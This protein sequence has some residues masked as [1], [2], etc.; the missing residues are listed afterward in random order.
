MIL[1]DQYAWAG[2]VFPQGNDVTVNSFGLSPTD[3]WGLMGG[4]G[5]PPPN[6]IM[7]QFDAPRHSIAIEHPGAAQFDL[8]LGDMLVGQSMNFFGP[9]FGSNFAGIISMA[10]FDRVEVIQ[11][12]SGISFIDNLYFGA[13][14]PAGPGAVLFGAAAWCGGAR[15][16][17]AER[18]C[19][20]GMRPARPISMA[21]SGSTAR[22]WACVRNGAGAGGRDGGGVGWRNFARTLNPSRRIGA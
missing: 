7:M 17:R 14:I 11:P 15:R 18:P 9:T 13:P 19:P 6:T 12:L 5:F 21:T 3:G 16:R 10:A 20:G 8:Y 4:M 1:T 22:T 2:V